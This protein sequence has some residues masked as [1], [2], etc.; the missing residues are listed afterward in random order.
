[1][2]GWVLAFTF[3]ISIVTGAVFGIAPALYARK[4]NLSESLKEGEGRASA[5][6]AARG[7]GKDW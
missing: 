1:L 3:L 6:L 7:C 5:G 2:D 4:T